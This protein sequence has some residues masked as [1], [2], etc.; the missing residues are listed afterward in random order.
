[1]PYIAMKSY[2]KDQAIKESFVERLNDLLLE[3]WGCR[4]EAITISIEEVAPTD[5]EEQVMK[6]EVEPNKE[7]MMMMSGKRCY[8]AE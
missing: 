8:K 3:V 7:H 4:Q 6:A 2:P 5:W 1:M